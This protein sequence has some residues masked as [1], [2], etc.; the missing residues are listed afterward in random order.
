MRHKEVMLFIG[1]IIKEEKPCLGC[2]TDLPA[3][4]EI[5]PVQ[6]FQSSRERQNKYQKQKTEDRKIQIRGKTHI[7]NGD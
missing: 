2:G 1:K 4:E 5:V 7:I 3:P 6:A